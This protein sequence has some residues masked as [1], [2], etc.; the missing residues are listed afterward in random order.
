MP[1]WVCT[2]CKCPS[3]LRFSRIRRWTLTYTSF[4]LISLCIFP[5]F[6]FHLISLEFPLLRCALVPKFCILFGFHVQCFYILLSFIHVQVLFFAGYLGAMEIPFFS[7]VS[8]LSFIRH[9][10]RYILFI[11]LHYIKKSL[12]LL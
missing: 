7:H 10:S 6:S 5:R 12:R 4:L 1:N 8:K 11:I 3:V 2:F 9:V